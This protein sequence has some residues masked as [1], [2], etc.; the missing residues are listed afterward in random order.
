[1]P[2]GIRRFIAGA[3]GVKGSASDGAD[4]GFRTLE[5]QSIFGLLFADR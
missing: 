3:Q 1:V 5:R 4:S 2:F